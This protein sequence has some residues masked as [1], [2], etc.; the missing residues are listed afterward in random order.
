MADTVVSRDRPLPVVYVPGQTSVGFEVIVPSEADAKDLG[1]FLD[2]TRLG[3]GRIRTQAAYSVKGVELKWMPLAGVMPSARDFTAAV[4]A[5][6]RKKN[7]AMARDMRDLRQGIEAMHRVKTAQ[8]VLGRYAI[9]ERVLQRF[10]ADQSLA[11]ALA[12][13]L[14]VH[15]DMGSW[16]R[17]FPQTLR[18]AQAA[19]KGLDGKWV[20][21]SDVLE[22]LQRFDTYYLP[23]LQDQE[24]A[25]EDLWS[26]SSP[27]KDIAGVALK[28]TREPTGR[29]QLTHATNDFKFFSGPDGQDA[30]AY[31]I[32]G[33]KEWAQA[34]GA[35]VESSKKLLRDLGRKAQR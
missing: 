28:A 25:L 23:Q 26:T 1:H 4:V 35:W 21:Q 5:W 6:S 9:E 10:A 19:A 14:A 32:D 12:G 20:W 33:L 8:A 2:S 30:M 17:Q 34:F 29:A 24:K 22:F 18:Q 11:Q 7:Y 15:E 3:K 16:V 27:L 13:T 31:P